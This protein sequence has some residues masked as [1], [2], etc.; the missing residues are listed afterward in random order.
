[1]KISF[2][3]IFPPGVPLNAGTQNSTHFFDFGGVLDQNVRFSTFD[4]ENAV[5]VKCFQGRN[6]KSD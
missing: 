5:K 1:M 3:E 2:D 6:I 4:L